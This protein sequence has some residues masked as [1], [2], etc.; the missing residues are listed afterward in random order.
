[1]QLPALCSSRALL[2]KTFTS[3]VKRERTLWRTVRDEE[4][5][6]AVVLHN[7]RHLEFEHLMTTFPA[8]R[9]WQYLDTCSDFFPELPPISGNRADSGPV[10]VRDIDYV[11]PQSSYLEFLSEA[12]SANDG[13]S[14]SDYIFDP[15]DDDISV[16]GSDSESSDSTDLPTEDSD[17]KWDVDREE[18]VTIFRQTLIV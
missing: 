11:L 17:D 5:W 14:D 7:C 15:A 16:E 8:L 18:A 10:N 13:S 9:T 6:S 12:C 3:S 2:T 4:E 1:M